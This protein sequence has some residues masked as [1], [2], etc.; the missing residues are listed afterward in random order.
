MVSNILNCLLQYRL[1]S[2]NI[3]LC[4][5]MLHNRHLVAV[6]IVYFVSTK[7]QAF[8]VLWGGEISEYLTKD[9]FSDLLDCDSYV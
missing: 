8:K 4:S 3:S 5:K 7:W 9:C 1:A 2:G 6:G